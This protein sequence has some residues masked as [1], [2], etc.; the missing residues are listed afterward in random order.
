ML[1]EQGRPDALVCGRTDID[2]RKQAEQR[3]HN[4]NVALREEIDSASM[5]EEI[6]GASASLQRCYACI[7]GRSFRLQRSDHRRDRHG[8]R[9]GG[10]RHSQA[11][12]ALVSAFR[13]RDCGAIPRA[14][15]ASELF[16]HEKRR[17]LLAPLSDV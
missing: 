9:T 15:I 2:D 16:G 1:N 6:V 13:E 17:F 11:F 14:L 10:P 5:F 12:P 3:L 7:E 4:E 8:Q